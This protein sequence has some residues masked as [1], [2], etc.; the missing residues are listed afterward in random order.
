MHKRYNNGNDKEKE[1][2]KLED[3]DKVSEKAEDDDKVSDK[4]EDKDKDEIDEWIEYTN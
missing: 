3:K 2:D 1:N 4:A